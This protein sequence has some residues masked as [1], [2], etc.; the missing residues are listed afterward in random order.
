MSNT[1]VSSLVMLLGLTNIEMLTFLDSRIFDHWRFSMGWKETTHL[2]I[3]TY[4]LVGNILENVP[5][6]IIQGLYLDLHGVTVV[7]IVCLV[8]SAFS[9]IMAVIRRV[10]LFV[11]L[12][13]HPERRGGRG[14]VKSGQD[15]L[16]V[17]LLPRSWSPTNG[18]GGEMSEVEQLRRESQEQREENQGLR[19]E[20]QRQRYEN[21]R[22]KDEN[23]R[24][25]DENQRQRDDNLLQ[26]DEIQRQR[27][28]IQRQRDDNQRQKDEIQRHRDENQQLRQRIQDLSQ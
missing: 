11:M 10:L 9:L 13:L 3:K 4:G 16:S 17:S 2:K 8:I 25:R 12:W 20:L 6:L 28:E 5:Q 19:G 18:G 24:H 22:Q 14:R 15:S 27:D 1:S 21:Q 7:T 23:Q 26:R